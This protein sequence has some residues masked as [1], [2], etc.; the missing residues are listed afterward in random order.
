MLD[1]S[2]ICE[3]IIDESIIEDELS[4]IDDDII[5]E[6]MEDDIMELSII[7]DEDM[8]PIAD[9][10][11]ASCESAPVASRADRAVVAMS[12]RNILISLGSTRVER[13]ARRKAWLGCCAARFRDANVT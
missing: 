10:D 11:E 7:D 12:R 4:I 2:D 3:D 9:D 13:A 5:D 8:S 6:S 1:A